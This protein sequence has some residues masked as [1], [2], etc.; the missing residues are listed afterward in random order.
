M[1]TSS[2]GLN[3]LKQFEG[4]SASAYNDVAGLATIG[5]GHLIK[6]NE[7][8][9]R[10]APIT[11]TEALDLLAQ[12]VKTAENEVNARVFLTPNQNEFDALVSLVYNI[13]VGAFASSTVLKR[14]NLGENQERVTQAWNMWNK[15]TVNGQ[16][17]VV[18]GLVNRRKSELEL[19]LE[20]SVSNMNQ[21]TGFHR[22]K[23]NTIQKL[24]FWSKM[25]D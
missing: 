2:T 10:S 12:D 13:G 21:G 15:A 17:Q 14:I 19:Y 25:R 9:L 5:Y 6:T 4:F 20:S 16:L 7:F 22:I 8:H 23:S 1:K 18:A 11:K 24:N 3:H